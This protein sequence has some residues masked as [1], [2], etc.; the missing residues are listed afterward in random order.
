MAST[1][2]ETGGGSLRSVPSFH[3]ILFGRTADGVYT[4]LKPEFFNGS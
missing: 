3:S 4:A 2:M 1:E